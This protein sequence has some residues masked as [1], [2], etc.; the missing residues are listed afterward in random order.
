MAA[1]TGGNE[2]EDDV[3]ARGQTG[4]TGADLLHDPGSLVASDHRQGQR[5]VPGDHVLIRMA[6]S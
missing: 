5:G 1:P 3:V 6:E 2:P 4:D